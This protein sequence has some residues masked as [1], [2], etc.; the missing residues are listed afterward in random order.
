MRGPAINKG[1]GPDRKRRG[2][3]RRSPRSM[4]GAAHFL[5]RPHGLRSHAGPMVDQ[6]S[7]IAVADLQLMRS[8]GPSVLM[9]ITDIFF[10]CL[11]AVEGTPGAASVLKNHP[12]FN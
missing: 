12:L 9:K 4:L 10:G 1:K 5:S 11:D 7:L 6:D 8:A 2:M 3:Q